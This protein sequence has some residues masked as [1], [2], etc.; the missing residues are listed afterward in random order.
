MVTMVRNLF[1]AIC[2][3]A[4]LAPSSLDGQSRQR[5]SVQ[6]SGIGN[7]LFGEPETQSQ[8]NFGAPASGGGA[9]VQLRFTPS[10]FSF[11]VGFQASLHGAETAPL[12]TGSGIVQESDQNFTL[13]GVFFEPRYVLGVSGN[14]AFYLSGRIALSRI[15]GDNEVQGFDCE[16]D[17]FCDNP[18]PVE[19]D[20]EGS[21]TGFTLNGGGGVLFALSDRV[22]LDLGATVGLKDFGELDLVVAGLPGGTTGDLG[23]FTNVVVRLGLAIGL[24]G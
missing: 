10:A 13:T 1:A 16:G 14:R 19:I 7:I 5:F 12:P 6:V 4:V 22:N 20:V 18:V 2:L 3:V 15:D 24:G 9:E 21:A 23:S 11:G 8:I 17:P